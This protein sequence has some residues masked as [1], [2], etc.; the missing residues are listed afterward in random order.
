MIY[1]ITQTKKK[2]MYSSKNSNKKLHI[3]K[4][5]L[6]AVSI[7]VLCL[8]TN[9]MLA[10][11]RLGATAN[12][13]VSRYR[14]PGSSGNQ[15]GK[16]NIGFNL[17]LAGDF[18]IIPKYLYLQPELLFSLRGYKSSS[19]NTK[20]NLTYIEV[21]VCATFKYPIK[22]AGKVYAGLGPNFAIALGGKVK[23]G[24]TN[25]KLKIG[26]KDTDDFKSLD[27]G[28]NFLLG[29]ELEENWFFNIRH[30]LGLSNVEPGNNG[31][32]VKTANWQF[33]LGYYF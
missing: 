13:N 23:S 27:I 18:E 15:K 20:Y 16:S 8:Q 12:M 1:L 26:N 21:P 25:Q 6:S 28:L 31:G 4:K 3:M 24:S 11:S 33:G 19:G 10:Q 14:L 22:N 29:F 30:T 32:T 17:G 2:C 9:T 7:V 5:I